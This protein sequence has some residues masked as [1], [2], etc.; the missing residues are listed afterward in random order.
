MP[1]HL[2]QMNAL[3]QEDPSTWEALKS[4]DFVVAKSEV[5]FTRLFTDHTLEQ[6]IKG[7]KR[8]G[9]IVGLSQSET[10]LDRIVTMTPHLARIVQEYLNTFPQASTSYRR[11][12]HYHLSGDVAVRTRANAL[13][14]RRSIELHCTSNPFIL[15]SP[16]KVLV[17]ST[18]IPSNAKDDIL[19]YA[20]KGQKRLRSSFTTYC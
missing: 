8:H 2:A 12:E 4:G 19:H 14:L 9:G 20:E 7:L 18:L 13:K 15:Q 5:P 1:V 17:S 10:A 11:S 16:L 6:E 3:E